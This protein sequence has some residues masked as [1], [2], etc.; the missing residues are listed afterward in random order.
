MAIVIN[1]DDNRVGTGWWRMAVGLCD[2]NLEP[3]L[4]VTEILAD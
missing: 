3:A 2:V 1:F 4:D